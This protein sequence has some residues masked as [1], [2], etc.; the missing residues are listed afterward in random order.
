MRKPFVSMLRSQRAV[1]GRRGLLSTAT[2]NQAEASGAFS[3]A[4]LAYLRA[5][6]ASADAR[7]VEWHRRIT[8]LAN[9]CAHERELNNHVM[10][11]L[12]YEKNSK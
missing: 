2:I 12:D 4:Q 10:H 8:Q 5:S 6:S 3:P 11:V 1:A 7:D 9:C